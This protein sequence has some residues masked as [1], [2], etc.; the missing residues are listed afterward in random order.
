MNSNPPV[1]VTAIDDEPH[2]FSGVFHE[3]NDPLDQPCRQLQLGGES[4]PTPRL[5]N[6]GDGALATR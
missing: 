6:C 3:R 2:G 5:G 4:S 1:T